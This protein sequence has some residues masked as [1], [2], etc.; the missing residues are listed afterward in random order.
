MQCIHSARLVLL[1][2][3]LE[4]AW[5]RFDARKIEDFGQ[6]KPP[7]SVELFDGASRYLAPGF[8]DIHVHGGN[9]SDFLDATPEAFLTIADY[10]F[11]E[12]QR[13]SAPP[14]QLRPTS[15]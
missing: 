11:R 7:D 3:I 12:A 15:A 14:W 10:H 5:I 6:G 9:G 2:R 13:A 8:I 1:D 4:N